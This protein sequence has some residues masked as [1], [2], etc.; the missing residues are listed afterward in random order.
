LKHNKKR[1]VALVYELLVRH[2]S[3]KIISEDSDGSKRTF[4]LIQ[5][6]FSPGN[7]IFAEKE[8]FDVI[9]ENR[10]SSEQIARKILG[11]VKAQARAT[12]VHLLNEKRD[13]MLHDVNHSFGK[14]IYSRYNISEYKLLASIC[15]L[16]ESFRKRSPVISESVDVLR[17][18]ESIVRY[19]LSDCEPETQQQ[20]KIDDLACAMAISRFK[21]R[22]GSLNESQRS[23]LGSYI[24][25]IMRSDRTRLLAHLKR[26]VSIIEKKIEK[27]MLLQEVRD[28]KIM[29]DRM[30]DALSS[31]R[32][33]ELSTDVESSVQDV[34]L[35]HGLCEQLESS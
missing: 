32:K 33:I 26:D 1:N 6:Y 9:R 7:P 12:D 5:K 30:K 16:I 23:L 13:L 2:L 28:D 29:S 15:M 22:Y 19:M 3:S 27:G 11:E 21:E 34:M 18:E 8:L 25:S 14:D 24:K 31:L 4:S 20:Q 35:Y 17:L 10:S